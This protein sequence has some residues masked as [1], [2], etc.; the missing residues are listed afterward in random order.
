[1][2]LSG[3]A[4]AALWENSEVLTPRFLARPP[5]AGANHRKIFLLTYA[6]TA[7]QVS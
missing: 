7:S 1:M 6:Q 5:A 4:G 2:P 3:E